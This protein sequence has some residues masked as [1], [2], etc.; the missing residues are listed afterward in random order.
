MDAA[1]IQRLRPMLDRYLG[2]FGHCFG[3]RELPERTRIYVTGQLSDLQ[4]KSIEPMADAAGIPPRT[5][6]QFLSR[7]LWDEAAMRDTVQHIV[8]GEHQHPC[9][10]GIFD[11]TGR[12]MVVVNWNTDLGD[13]WEWAEDPWYP[14]RFSNFAYKLGVNMIVYGMSH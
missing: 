14:W 4:R 9:S 11:E 3:R 7:H 10:I 5:L 12:L 1:Q 8:A 2:E 6:Q 13:A